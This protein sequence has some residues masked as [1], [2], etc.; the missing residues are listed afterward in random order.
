M[1]LFI[2]NRKLIGAIVLALLAVHQQYQRRGAGTLLVQWGLR[3]SESLRLPAYL[4]ASPAGHQ[5]Y[6]KLGFQQIDTVLV[7]AEEW[8]GNVD[9]H[10]IAMLKRPE[11]ASSLPV[12]G[13]LE[14]T[15]GQL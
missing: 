6:S 7:R 2:R 9:K 11:N 15:A 1:L 5:L 13:E 3:K 4:E 14:G 12:K 8:D 10:Y